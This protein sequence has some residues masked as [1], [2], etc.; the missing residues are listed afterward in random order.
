MSWVFLGNKNLILLSGMGIERKIVLYKKYTQVRCILFWLENNNCGSN[1]S[2]DHKLYS[3]L[4]IIYDVLS[5]WSNIWFGTF[6]FQICL[7]RCRTMKR[8]RFEIF[9]ASIAVQPI[10]CFTI[11]FMLYFYVVIQIFY[12]LMERVYTF[13]LLHDNDGDSLLHCGRE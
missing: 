13:T 10:N 6:V 7:T 11:I 3:H 4:N 9:I 8:C 2:T 5:M 1:Y 12:I